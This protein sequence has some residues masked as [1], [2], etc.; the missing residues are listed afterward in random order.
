MSWKVVELPGGTLV[1]PGAEAT[2]SPEPVTVIGVLR[3]SVDV[4]LLLIVKMWTTDVPMTTLPKS[5]HL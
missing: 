3:V 5:G 4:P 1:S 2:K